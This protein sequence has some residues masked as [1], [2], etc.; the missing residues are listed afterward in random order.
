[1]G[2]VGPEGGQGEM[3][4]LVSALSNQ[5]DESASLAGLASIPSQVKAISR[6][7]LCGMGGSAIAGD[8]V[9]PLL[10]DQTTSLTVWRNYGLPHWVN[11]NDLVIACSYSG[12]TE[13]CL[14]AVDAAGRL[15]CRRVAITSGGKLAAQSEH[16]FFGPAF[17]VIGLPGGLPPRASLGYG[18]GALIRLLGRLGVISDGPYQLS[19]AIAQ[20][21]L[22]IPGLSDPLISGGKTA[23]LEDINGNVSPAALASKLAGKI[24]VIYTAGH[25]ARGAGI[26]LRAQ[27]NE[28]SKVPVLLAEF[29]ELDHNDLV[30]WALPEDIKKHFVLLILTGKLD[31]KNMQKRVVVTRDLLAGEFNGIWEIKGKGRTALARVMSLVQYGDFLSCHL[32]QATGIDPVP[33]DRIMMLKEALADR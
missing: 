3:F 22:G 23:N 7:I 20:L 31:N 1:M 4:R 14:S 17:S 5:L 15:G 6:I 24:P 21:Q 9:Q 19:D 29:P 16:P 33:V 27:L 8:L 10:A 26:R 18:F 30:G 11:K 25:E 2:S 32:A 28:N 12:N 13:E